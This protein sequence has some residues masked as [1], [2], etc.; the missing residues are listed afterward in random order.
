MSVIIVLICYCFTLGGLIHCSK[1]FD[2][3][4]TK[5]IVGV[6]FGRGD[7]IG[8]YIHLN[9]CD[10]S[11]NHIRFYKNGVEL[12]VAFTNNV[13][14]ENTNKYPLSATSNSNNNHYN[15]CLIPS[16][17]YYPAISLYR[18][19]R[20]SVHFSNML[21]IELCYSVV[22]TCQSNANR[23]L[24]LYFTLFRHVFA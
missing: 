22:F 2:G 23:F 12:G 15:G 21:F 4:M 8:C 13:N 7:I 20:T 17:I 10:V 16:A 14:H 11:E 1:R 9:D 18:Q 3:Y 6:G 5:N 19:A 24:L